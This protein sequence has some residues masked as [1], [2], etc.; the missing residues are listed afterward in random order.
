MGSVSHACTIV[1]LL[2]GTLEIE[3]VRDKRTIFLLSHTILKE[4]ITNPIT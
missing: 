4:F 1:L 3:G 2:T